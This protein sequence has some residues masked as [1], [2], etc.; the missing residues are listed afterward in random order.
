[1]DTTGTRTAGTSGENTGTAGS[2]RGSRTRTAGSG[3]GVS[4]DIPAVYQNSHDDDDGEAQKRRATTACY[5]SIRTQRQIRGQHEAIG[6]RPTADCFE[7]GDFFPKN[8]FRT[9]MSVLVE[10]S[11]ELIISFAGTTGRA[12]AATRRTHCCP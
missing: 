2:S 10:D 5:E 9:Q 4:I 12:S 7:C 1:M 3:S 8:D 11:K 6:S